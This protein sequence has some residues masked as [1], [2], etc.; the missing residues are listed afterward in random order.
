[1]PPKRARPSPPPHNTPSSNSPPPPSLHPKSRRLFDRFYHYTRRLV[2]LGQAHSGLER[3]GDEPEYLDLVRGAVVASK[4]SDELQELKARP[5]NSGS[6]CMSEV[7]LC[8]A[9]PIS[10][11]LTFFFRRSSTRSSSA[12]SPS[13]HE[14]ISATRPPVDLHSLHPRIFSLSGTGSYAFSPC[15]LSQLPSHPFSL[16]EQRPHP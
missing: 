9:L 16:P 6:L 2:E 5:G 15:C 11:S 3:E 10:L 14:S 13:M 1:M 8:L 7:R 12:S 4:G